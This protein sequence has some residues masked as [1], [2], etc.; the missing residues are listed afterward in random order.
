MSA[1][2]LPT[3]AGGVRAGALGDA[4]GHSFFPSKNL[5]ALGDAGAVTT[6]DD[7]LADALRALRNYG[8]HRKYEN[9]YQGVNSRLD[10]LQ[11]A[12]LREFD[13]FGFID[14]IGTLGMGSLIAKYGSLGQVLSDLRTRSLQASGLL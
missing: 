10:E 7:A 8:S 1:C 3:M 13:F 4:A 5:G 6:H 9:I 2:S 12:L 11:A 14:G